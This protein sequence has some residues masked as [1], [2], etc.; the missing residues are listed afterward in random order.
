MNIIVNC[1]LIFIFVF[2]SIVI[3]IP[4]IEVGNIFKNKLFLFG[5][6]VLFQLILKSTYKIRNKC[7]GVDLKSIV[8]N[9]LMVGVY[10]VIG[11]S[12][13]IDTL[14]MEKTRSI[15]L[16]YLKNPNSHAFVIS[17]IISTFILC[18]IILSYIV[19][20]KKDDCDGNNNLII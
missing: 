8:N 10:G 7:N 19:T 14:N 12:L 11:Y 17:F 15:I 18:C 1:L 13:F 4:G 6:L 5:G 2:V 9:S 3:G 20:G 16:P